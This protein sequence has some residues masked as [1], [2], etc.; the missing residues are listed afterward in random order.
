MFG[1][2]TLTLE[3]KQLVGLKKLCTGALKSINP[4]FFLLFN[5]IYFLLCFLN[6]R[7]ETL[8]NLIIK[9]KIQEKVS[10][11]SNIHNMLELFPR[12]RIAFSVDRIVKSFEFL[13]ADTLCML[14]DYAKMSAGSVKNLLGPRIED[15]KKRY[16]QVVQYFAPIPSKCGSHA[17]V[18]NSI[19]LAKYRF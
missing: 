17:F 11:L 13:K 15:V 12:L 3:A 10:F 6:L 2:E 8:C 4:N 9:L 7:Y 16:M 1:F 19:G 5:M 18:M 14:H